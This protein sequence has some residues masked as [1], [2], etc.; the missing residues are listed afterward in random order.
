MPT[1]LE[2]HPE[3]KG[4]TSTPNPARSESFENVHQEAQ[5]DEKSGSDESSQKKKQTQQPQTTY[6]GSPRR[7]FINRSTSNGNHQ[8][9]NR[10]NRNS[11]ANGK[12]FTNDANNNAN[13]NKQPHFKSSSTTQ[14]KPPPQSEQHQK[15]PNGHVEP[16]KKPQNKFRSITK[17]SNNVTY[18]YDNK[19]SAPETTKPSDCFNGCGDT[20]ENGNTALTQNGDDNTPRKYSMEFLHRVGYK[21]S[22]NSQSVVQSSPKALKNEASLMALKLALG[23]NSGNYT[24]LY[25]G[26][27][28]GNQVMMQQQQFQY[29]RFQQIHQQ[30]QL[31]QMQRTQQGM[32]ARNQQHDTFQRRMYQQAIY[33]DQ[34]VPPNPLTC[35]CVPGQQQHQQQPIQRNYQHH[36]YSP[37]YQHRKQGDR[38]DFHNNSKKNRQGFGYQNGGNF[39]SHKDFHQNHR[40]GPLA[41]SQ[42]FSEDDSNVRKNLNYNRTISED[43]AFRSLSPTPPSSSKSS[44]PGASEKFVAKDATLTAEN[45]FELADDSASTASSSGPPVIA[46]FVSDMKVSVSTPTLLGPEEPARNVDYWIDNNFGSSLH[47]QLSFSAENLDYIHRE[48]PITIIK[49]PPSVNGMTKRSY[50]PLQRS[51][52]YDPQYPFE[53]Y[54]ARAEE[55]EMRIAPPTL[56]M[57]SEFDTLSSQ[58]WDKFQQFQQTRET[59]HSKMVLWRDL[60]NAVRVSFI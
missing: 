51:L 55:S 39:K 15:L 50:H 21:I 3:V 41:K 59:Y 18:H 57:G 47:N 31:Q 1:T 4:D 17:S 7:K 27:M 32:Y 28:Y 10:Q 30:Q 11:S 35:R 48:P 53:Y 34:E 29:A 56:R 43:H 46:S 2:H 24:H 20:R 22:N 49:R 38:R 19:S 58:M 37:S 9:G 25:S 45:N 42:S 12:R 40:I 26:A 14:L 6:N 54:L 52:L 33:P 44:S 8:N 5:P 23:D 36:T 60:H 16:M 13:V